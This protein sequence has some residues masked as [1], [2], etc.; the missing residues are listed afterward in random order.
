MPF[1]QQNWIVSDAQDVSAGGE[2]SSGAGP[3]S[4][5]MKKEGSGDSDKTVCEQPDN[6]MTFTLDAE[7]IEK[8]LFATRTSESWKAC[9]KE[10]TTWDGSAEENIAKY[11]DNVII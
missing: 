4:V 5:P 11:K 1:P 7:T 6:T 3:S 2:N 10:G 8:I 9:V